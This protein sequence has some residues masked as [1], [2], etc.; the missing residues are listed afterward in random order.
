MKAVISGG[1]GTGKSTLL[2][3]LGE[4][5]FHTIPEAARAIIKEEEMKAS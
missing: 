2:K 4:Q 3:K 1:P 5:G